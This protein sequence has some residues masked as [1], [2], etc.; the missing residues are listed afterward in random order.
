MQFSKQILLNQ[1][2]PRRGFL[3]LARAKA[4]RFVASTLAILYSASAIAQGIPPTL[5][6]AARPATNSHFSDTGKL[7]K[8]GVLTAENPHLALGGLE[9]VLDRIDVFLSPVAVT[10]ECLD[11]R[12]TPRLTVDET[13][14]G[15][16][17]QLINLT[18]RPEHS[19]ASYRIDAASL[20]QLDAVTTS[21]VQEVPHLG[22]SIHTADL[23][24][25]AEGH[26]KPAVFTFNSV[27]G[28][29]AAAKAP[30]PSTRE[31]SKAYATLNE[32]GQRVIAGIVT[33]PEQLQSGPASNQPD[34]ISKALEQVSPS[35]RYLKI[36]G[37]EPDNKGAYA[38][39]LP[40][41][42]RPSRGPGPSFSIRYASTGATGVLGRGWDLNFSSIQ[43]RG[44]SPV[45]HPAYETEDYLLDGAELIALDG[46]GR[47][48]PPL[49]KGGPIIPRLS[50]ERV[51]RL[52]NNTSGLIV[53]RHGSGPNN[54]FWEVWNPNS[55]VTRLYG[56][57]LQDDASLKLDE[58][59]NA[60]LRGVVHF[61]TGESATV[62][63]QW[64][65][66]QEYDNQPAKSG[67]SYHYAQTSRGHQC[68]SASWG[69]DCW[70][71]LRLSSVD[72]NQ[73]FGKSPGV[74]G[75]ERGATTALFE[76]EE[77]EQT[78][79]N[80]DGRLGFFQAQEFWL[81]QINVVYTPDP[82]NLWLSA[83]NNTVAATAKVLLVAEDGKAPQDPEAS[84]L[85]AIDGKVVYSSHTFVLGD[86]DQPCMNYERVL[87]S[88]NVWANPLVD[89]GLTRTNAASPRDEVQSFGFDYTGEACA[90]RWSDP[91]NVETAMSSDIGLKAPGGNLDFPSALLTD[92]G[93]ELQQQRSL[94]GTSRTE[95]TGASLYVGVGPIDNLTSKPVSGGVKGGTT[96]TK[97][98]AY[99]T[100]VDVTG[101][102]IDDMVFRADGKLR[103]CAGSRDPSNKFKMEYMRCGEILG[104][105]EISVSDTSTLSVSAEGFAPANTFGAVGYNQSTNNTYV[106]FTDQD[107]DGLV[108]LAA[109]GQVLYGQG[110]EKL[111]SG[112]NAVRFLPKR[113]LIPPVPGQIT[114]AALQAR[115]PTQLRESVRQVETRLAEI[116]ASLEKLQYSQTTL[117]WESPLDGLVSISGQLVFD[118]MVAT[119]GAWP[120]TFSPA[121]F[122]ALPAEVKPY[123]DYLAEKA[124]CKKWSDEPTCYQSVSAPFSPGYEPAE[125]ASFKFTATPQS[126]LQVSH[127]DR[128]ER[129][130]KPCSDSVALTREPANS[131]SLDLSALTFIDCQ[132]TPAEIGNDIHIDP[133]KLLRV[134]AGDVI[135]VTFSIHPHYGKIVRPW[136][137]FT[138]ED[139][140]GDPVFRFLKYGKITTGGTKAGIERAIKCA[141]RD[142]GATTFDEACRLA[143]LTRYEYDL[144]SGT[145]T[146]APGAR[147]VLPAGTEREIRGRFTLPDLSRQY[148]VFLDLIGAE[149]TDADAGRTDI[150]EGT[151]LARINATSACAAGECTV[152]LSAFCKGPL[153][154]SPCSGILT[155][156]MPHVLA[157]RLTILHKGTEIPVRDI[158]SS[159]AALR[160]SKAPAIV[161]RFV[162]KT[163]PNKPNLTSTAQEKTIVYLPTRMGDPDLEVWRVKDG[164]FDNPDNGLEEDIGPTFKRIQFDQIQRMETENVRMIRMRQTVDL[165]RFAREIAGFLDERIGIQVSPYA[166]NFSGY[167]TSK[168]DDETDS[169]GKRCKAAE[170][171]VNATWYTGDAAPDTTMSEALRLTHLFSNLTPQQQI[172]SA[173][174]LIGK[175]LDMLDVG[176]ELLTDNAQM[177]RRGY[178]LPAK[179]NPLSCELISSEGEVLAEPLTSKL[180][181]DLCTYRVLANFAMLDFKDDGAPQAKALF[182]AFANS[183]EAAFE[184]K[185][186]AAV[187]G[188]PVKFRELTGEAAGNDDCKPTPSNA[189]TCLGVYGVKAG[190]SQGYAF[191]GAGDDVF[192]RV[193]LNKRP[194][195]TVAF[196]SSIMKATPNNSGPA[197]CKRMPDYATSSEMER[198][199]DCVTAGDDA[200]DPNLKYVPSE[201]S[202]EAVYKITE[203]NKFFGRNRIFEFQ[204]R[205]LD[206]V[207]FHLALSPKRHA[208][209][210][211]ANGETIRGRFSLFQNSAGRQMIRR[212]A[213]D[214]LPGG[215]TLRCPQ[216]NPLVPAPFGTDPWQ[217]S[218]LPA[219]CRPWTKLGWTELLLGAQYRTYSDTQRTGLAGQFSLKRRR[220][221]LRLFPEIEV[222]AEQ[223]SISDDSCR[224]VPEDKSDPNCLIPVL[225][226]LTTGKLAIT[227]KI[228]DNTKIILTAISAPDGETGDGLLR[229]LRNLRPVLQVF[230]PNAKLWAWDYAATSGLN[231]WRRFRN[232]AVAFVAPSPQVRAVSAPRVFLVDEKFEPHIPKI[233]GA[234]AF[235]AQS[236]TGQL[237]VP[238]DFLQARFSSAN[239]DGAREGK[240]GA[241]DAAVVACGTKGDPDFD[242]CGTHLKK[243]GQDAL[244][245][246]GINQIPLVHHFAGP[247]VDRPLDVT[248]QDSVCASELPDREASCWQGIDDTV[249]LESGIKPGIAREPL[250]AISAL[251]GFE[252]PPIAA[253]LSEFDVLKDIT[254]LDR[255]WPGVCPENGLDSAAQAADHP[256]ARPKPAPEEALVEAFAPIQRSTSETVSFNGGAVLLNTSTSTT[257]RNTLTAYLDLNGDG[258]PEL[259][260]N[261]I[262]ELTSPVGLS[263]REWWR[264]FRI[265]PGMDGLAK[266]VFADGFG[267]SATSYST[268]TGIGLSPS[269]A[270]LFKTHGTKNGNKSGSPDPNVE[271][272]FEFNVENGHDK[273]FVDLRDFNGDGLMDSVGGTTVNEELKLTYSTGNSLGTSGQGAFTVDGQPTQTIFYNTSHSAGFG[274]RLG[275]QTESGSF[276]TG[277]GLSHRDSGS[278]GALIDFTGDGRPDI[279]VPGDEALTVYPNLGNGFGKGRRH[280]I[281]HWKDSATSY[282]ETALFDGGAQ[283]TYGFAAWFVKVVF[284]PG[285]KHSRNQTRELL[286]IRDMNGDGVP[287]IANVSGAFKPLGADLLPFP[288]L[289][290]LKADVHYNPDAGYHFLSRIR[291]P[292]GGQYVLRHNLF[293]NEG[294]YQGKPV[295]ALTEVAQF[296]GFKSGQ[297][298]GLASDGQDVLLTRY[299]YGNGYYNRAERQ[300]YGF[301][302]RTVTTYGCDE[303]NEVASRRDRCLNTVALEPTLS[304]AIVTSAGFRRLQK[305]DEHYSNRDVLT[306]GML[307]SQVTEGSISAPDQA[308]AVAFTPLSRTLFRYSIDNLQCT[309]AAESGDCLAASDAQTGRWQRFADASSALPRAWD[310]STSY[311]DNGRVFGGDRPICATVEDCD[312]KL[313]QATEAAGF[314]R[315]QDRFWAQQSGSVRQRF[316]RLEIVA[317]T[318]NDALACEF[319]SDASCAGRSGLKSALA[320]DHD[321]WGQ[322]LRLDNIAETDPN[323][324]PVESAGNHVDIGY[325]RRLT[326]Q[327]SAP[328]M[329]YPILGLA[330]TVQVFDLPWHQGDE[331][332][333]RMREAVYP[334]DNE[335]YAGR[336][337]PVDI[338]LYPGTKSGFAFAP[339]ICRNF[340]EHMSKALNNGQHTMQSA[341]KYAYDVDEDHLPVGG[342]TTSDAVIRHQLV[343]YDDFGNLVHSVSPL[344]R[345]MDWIE[346]RFSYEADP[347]KAT[348]T[349]TEL[350]RCVKSEAGAGANS[351]EL[352][353]P[354]VSRCTFGLDVLPELVTNIGLTHYSTSRIDTHSGLVAEVSDINRNSLLYDYD[355]WG[356]PRLV[357]RDWGNAAR[358][359]QTFNALLKRAVAKSDQI[360]GNPDAAAGTGGAMADVT[361]WRILALADYSCMPAQDGGKAENCRSTVEPDGVLRSNLRRF[362]SSDTYTGL[363]QPGNTTRETA[364]F[365]DGSGRV[366]QT[367]SEADVCLQAASA[368]FGADARNVP[369]TAGL[370]ARCSKPGNDNASGV[371]GVIVTPSTAIDALGRDLVTYEPYAP[372]DEPAPRTDS[373]MRLD[374][375][376]GA[377]AQP[378]PLMSATFDGAGRP[379]KIASRLAGHDPDAVKGTTQ[380]RYRIKVQDQAPARFETLSLSPRCSASA[381]W[382][383]SRGL[384]TSVFEGQAQR[385]VVGPVDPKGG[386]VPTGTEYSRDLM[387]TAEACEPIEGLA[388]DWTNS[389]VRTDYT[390]D[391]LQ[392]L[393]RVDY[394]LAGSTDT[395]IVVN[396]DLLGRTIQMQERNSGCTRYS[397]DALDLLVSEAGFRF[398]AGDAPVCGATYQAYNEKR[399]GYAGDRLKTIAY[400]SLDEQGGVSDKEDAVEFYYDR[401]PFA[402]L[403]GT[404]VEADKYVLNDQANQHLI[405]VTG[406]FC[407]NCVG[408]AALVSD[409]SGARTFSY[410]EL[411]LVRREL[412]SIVG[413]LNHV[414]KSAGEAET[415]VPELATYEVENSYSAF[416][417]LVLE[418]FSESAPANPAEAC[419]AKID[420][421]LARFSIGR[422]Y[423][424]NGDLAELRFN[425]KAIV[426]SAQDALGRPAVRWTANGAMTGNLYDPVDLR[427]NR[428]MTLTGANQPVQAVGYQYDGSG[429]I[430]DYR[431]RASVAQYDSAFAFTYDPVN[432][433]R[434]FKSA[435]SASLGGA[436]LSMSGGGGY[437]YDARH[438][439]TKRLLDI[440]ENGLTFRRSWA[441][442]YEP[443]KGPFHAPKSVAFSMGTFPVGAENPALQTRMTA[444]T[445]DEV[446]RMTSAAAPEDGNA[447]GTPVLSNRTLTWDGQGRLTHV[448]GLDDKAAND[449]AKWLREH[450][451]Y[452]AGGNRVLKM[453]QPDVLEPAD[454]T[455]DGTPAE[456]ELKAAVKAQPRKIE[457][458][459]IYMTPYY[460]RSYDARGTVQLSV[461]TLPA[462]SMTAPADQS[463]DPVATYLYS[464]LPVGSM[465]AAVTAYGEPDNA[466]ATLI[467]R[468]EYDPYGLPLTS[469]ALAKAARPD[470]PALNT[471]HGK[472]LDRVTGFSSFGARYYSRDA[473]IWLSPDPNLG[474]GMRS[475]TSV[476]V[477][478]FTSFG[479]DPVGRTDQDGNK[480]VAIVA[481]G[482]GKDDKNAF[483]QRK[484]DFGADFTRTV[485]TGQDLV[486][487]LVSANSTKRDPIEKLIIGS[488]GSG[489]GLYMNEQAG[490]YSDK[491]NLFIDAAWYLTIPKKGW[492]TISDI[493]AEITAGNITFAKGAV[494]CLLSCRSSNHPIPGFDSFA[495]ALSEQIKDVYVIGA[496]GK[497]SPDHARRG[498]RP[499]DSNKYR[500]GEGWFYQSNKPYWEIWKNGK[501]VGSIPNP[502]DPT[503][504]RIKD[505]VK[506]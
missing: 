445:Y 146:S 416:G 250:F 391:D 313:V 311:A 240:Q 193:T 92:L 470:L 9:V 422:S 395:S 97:S 354:D 392:Q 102:G 267:V 421:C 503:T 486:S 374:H 424:P 380:F 286:Q 345:N 506:E 479:G 496:A 106:Y 255:D 501:Y 222:K 439:F 166:A 21:A 341:M 32:R 309:T 339:G 176:E 199:Q 42:L 212:S 91:Q 282:S 167:W 211:T 54:Y 126:Y 110:E 70:A 26:T 449:N 272:S 410:N 33:L 195:R 414:V 194:G 98:E 216:R 481:Y 394:P 476:N 275:F 353:N 77:R 409:R 493:T 482:V 15:D 356:R 387:R 109:Y 434:S 308:A 231:I 17:A 291:T 40:M 140:D 326:M 383:D 344:S 44:P 172:S 214:I 472:E 452:D 43:V 400:H 121:K 494:I 132:P 23:S 73:A 79:F 238:P 232:V 437:D 103:Y 241:Y 415:S 312:S 151:P 504:V 93:F 500:S 320:F 95:E 269:T 72:Y 401:Y 105:R 373:R 186:T 492:A 262:A 420:N 168:L 249:L 144:S 178:R 81:R 435:T 390:Y 336:A 236:T 264:Y 455:A 471:F 22:I 465:T 428:L 318:P 59:S 289:G 265:H 129:T 170:E 413:P 433:L 338:C 156:G 31:A 165:C 204:G 276:A 205:P 443:R 468:R 139:V 68:Q 322:V 71:A 372:V 206:V 366:I 228:R 202:Y 209:A 196:S 469:E 491:T 321:Q 484:R 347:F 473:G 242:G 227:G 423:S 100:L 218:V 451:T 217:T 296:D 116:S 398:E 64:G 57:R 27:Y 378:L 467:A 50:G 314:N 123:A 122:E 323:W 335:R 120:A 52:R 226:K 329:G 237:S 399:Y 319:A 417:D 411:G 230:V 245:F 418:K 197:L 16:G 364:A 371:A 489:T 28:N 85:K 381:A 6:A 306:Q 332:P 155:E 456:G 198:K 90:A 190:D 358:E 279:V 444:F 362:E 285:V 111:A 188:V 30:K 4:G 173:Q 404:P 135:H 37:I 220:E 450:Y 225:D 498:G 3:S 76:W 112:E 224:N 157:L 370:A 56:A 174:L 376:L 425:G 1:A 294:P 464:D 438:R 29:W 412:R 304:E 65:L 333:V 184:I 130:T 408:Q 63:G 113:G 136:V 352:A 48:I 104:P 248:A 292:A 175:V 87:K 2:N 406:R 330:E 348:A 159:L 89:G 299:S 457:A 256:P 75:W 118:D 47:D 277:M 115:V 258:Y 82:E 208:D 298:A 201:P 436:I 243:Q 328:K 340:G 343:A 183:T 35:A 154:D 210:H 179:I 8:S 169:Y 375:L 426:R 454:Q 67:T 46:N 163:D 429:N 350:T 505:Y 84:V 463:E 261:G 162:E 221:L 303:D 234:W 459:T 69:G 219:T 407:D 490:L 41:L 257:N 271:P 368:L 200:I 14:Y 263:R 396:Y 62:I 327:G 66:A 191:P 55:Q 379:L 150:P 5:Q 164:A 213:A 10:I 461:G 223:Y 397:Y 229:R 427:L 442:S 260:S 185:L 270:A 251:W 377:A 60:L 440:T 78:R 466:S 290:D 239:Y 281:P 246:N 247:T 475:P 334:Q 138:Y 342:A 448:R 359:N 499:I 419:A 207:Q 141:W 266:E 460:A 117:A 324:K 233:G 402:Q 488:H 485:H 431:N 119:D 180:L 310:G 83:A 189:S 74:K 133:T 143:A 325:A 203:A 360:G 96:F 131:Q 268:G 259:V 274:V 254:C 288:E 337:L 149:T 403:S 474:D 252:R 278:Q 182:A 215:G 283:Y 86:D 446:G 88:Y 11:E 181:D 361:Q 177:T 127:F 302:D 315:E 187:N 365:A 346:R 273:S 53:R 316:I 300:F 389:A 124:T 148:D 458:A 51:F 19:C 502:V 161:S 24:S 430:L 160:W 192:Q 447:S 287:D 25:S 388:A 142:P 153:P 80:S 432:R 137:K 107:G 385:Y 382:T 61:R 441:Y 367:L 38:V 363:L 483:E 284:N 297:I 480:D 453:H 307:L 405:D 497:S 7:K 128:Q 94:L 114:K 462:V 171:W 349:T 12:Q 99:S 477:G 101:D 39:E 386:Q 13:V 301:S 108:D 355:R 134:K 18:E 487:A 152:D 478:S 295:W 253:F 235:F 331:K 34:T 49:Y 369:A 36:N 495:E 244:G 305:L 393:K 125:P 357:A 280:R 145:L 351:P 147:R 58:A 20:T 384:T 317:P 45:Y 158:S 293:G